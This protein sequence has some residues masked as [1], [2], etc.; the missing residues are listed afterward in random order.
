MGDKTLLDRVIDLEETNHVK[1]RCVFDC[2]LYLAYDY[3]GCDRC[4]I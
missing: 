4:L 3:T 2:A 1:V